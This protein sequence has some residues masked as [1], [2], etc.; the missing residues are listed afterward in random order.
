MS[1]ST[2]RT[3]G[4]PRSEASR[5]VVLDAAYDILAEKGIAAFS[6]D[7]V[8]SR[9]GVARTTIYRWWPNK[10]QL[11][12]ESFLEAVKPQLSFNQTACAGDDLRGLLHSNALMLSGPG[13][14][15]V[16]SILAEAQRDRTVADLFRESYATPL[17][18]EGRALIQAGIDRGEFRADLSPDRVL[19][20]GI[21]AIYLRLM[22]G[23]RFD[24]A[25]VNEIID[26]TLAGCWPRPGA[27]P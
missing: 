2:A 26:T 14:R 27:A 7:A 4:R 25:W 12:I 10:G 13:G 9:A 15:I 6:I 17:R 5:Q 16:A 23:Q 19:D 21:G 8:A 18:R 20:C 24:R 22:L 11:A 1:E 3:G